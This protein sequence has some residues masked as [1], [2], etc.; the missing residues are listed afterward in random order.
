[1]DMG[2]LEVIL[3][4]GKLGYEEGA[5]YNAIHVGAA[6]AGQKFLKPLIAITFQL[7]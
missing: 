7:V 3:A 6:A 2:H 4:D 5:P 1:M